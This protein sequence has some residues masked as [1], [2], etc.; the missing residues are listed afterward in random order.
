MPYADVYISNG[1]YGGVMLAIQ[2]DLP[3]VVAGIDEGKNEI[4]ARIGYFKLGIDL[5]TQ[6]PKPAQLKSAVEKI[7]TDT[8]YRKNVTALSDELSMYNSYALCA[9]YAQQ[10]IKEKR[11]FWKQNIAALNPGFQN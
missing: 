2:N 1:G 8:V 10:L 7:F 11:A 9:D 6:W 3:M 5:R 4:N